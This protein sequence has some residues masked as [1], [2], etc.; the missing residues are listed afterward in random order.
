[1]ALSNP[2]LMSFLLY[3]YKWKIFTLHY[4]NWGHIVKNTQKSL[5]ICRLILAESKCLSNVSYA[6]DN[7][8]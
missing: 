7:S 2:I 6:A 8:V 5:K 1:M 3:Y 4:R